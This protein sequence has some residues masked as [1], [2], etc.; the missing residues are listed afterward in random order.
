M[1]INKEVKDN[2]KGTMAQW[3]NG[4]ELRGERGRKGEGENPLPGGV[5]GG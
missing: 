3:R 5:W 1:E 2:K 4:R